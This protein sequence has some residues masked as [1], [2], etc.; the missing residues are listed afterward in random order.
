[1]TMAAHLQSIL[2]LLVF[3][4]LADAQAEPEISK[5]GAQPLVMQQPLPKQNRDAERLMSRENYE[6][7]LHGLY[8]MPRQDM[9]EYSPGGDPFLRP[10]YRK[11]A[12]V[13]HWLAKR[14]LEFTAVDDAGAPAG[15]SLGPLRFRARY[16]ESGLELGNMPSQRDFGL[17]QLRGRQ[18]YEQ[19][20][21]RDD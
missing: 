21:T 1:M 18:Y 13:L 10:E 11:N 16:F 6:R 9:R 15:D 5:F 8:G 7:H 14:E 2:V 17:E 12:D 19:R 20:V 4:N 3:A